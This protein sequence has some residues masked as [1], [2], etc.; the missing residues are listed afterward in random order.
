MLLLAATSSAVLHPTRHHVDARSLFPCARKE[1]LKK[2][3][4]EVDPA[5]PRAQTLRVRMS[6]RSKMLRMHFGLTVAI[7]AANAAVAIWALAAFPPDADG[8]GTLKMGNCDEVR[9]LNSGL[10]LIIH[11][12]ISPFLGAGNYCMQTLAAPTR[13]EMDLARSKGHSLNVGAPSLRNHLRRITRPRVAL[14]LLLGLLS[15]LLHLIWNSVVFASLPVVSYPNAMVTS[16]WRETSHM[17]WQAAPL[18]PPYTLQNYN[19]SGAWDRNPTCRRNYQT[20]PVSNGAPI[21]PVVP[22]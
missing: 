6:K 1:I 4:P 17:S 19:S 2:H 18:P 10:H 3:I 14:W 11:V 16:D 15:T 9:A 13:A 8:V 12:L 20:S 22:G 21:G 5:D 7:L